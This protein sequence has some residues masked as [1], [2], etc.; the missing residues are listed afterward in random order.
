MRRPGIM[1]ADDIVSQNVQREVRR[2]VW[3]AARPQPFRTIWQRWRATW[4]VF[5]GR[6]DACLWRDQ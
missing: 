2:G 4:L 5:T 1:Y 6:A 3:V